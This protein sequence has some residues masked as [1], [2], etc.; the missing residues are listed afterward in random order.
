M[1]SK[2]E[3]LGSEGRGAATLSPGAWPGLTHLQTPCSL[4]GTSA[5]V[6]DRPHLTLPLSS[7]LHLLH[8]QHPEFSPLPPS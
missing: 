6:S 3:V 1:W 7:S 8:A 2:W 5:R 4:P